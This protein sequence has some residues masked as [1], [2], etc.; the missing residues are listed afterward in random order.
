MIKTLCLTLLGCISIGAHAENIIRISAPIA[1]VGRWE[2]IPTVYSDWVEDGEL[3]AC[4][5][6]TP[7]AASFPQGVRFTQSRSCF[8][9]YT[10]TSQDY[11]Q[12]TLTKRTRPVGEPQV[13]GKSEKKNFNN[14]GIGASTTAYGNC[15][16]KFGPATYVRQFGS[17]STIFNWYFNGRTISGAEIDS[18]V[19]GELMTVSGSYVYYS[20]C[21]KVAG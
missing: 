20:I 6:W 3:V 1:G 13:S 4:N 16:Y 15:Q 9:N 18:Y 14:T 21:E 10:M 7:K 19:M 17:G 12:N 8:Q 11:E 2:P 5:D